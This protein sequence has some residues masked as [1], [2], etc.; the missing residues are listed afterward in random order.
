MLSGPSSLI[1]LCRF[2]HSIPLPHRMT[3]PCACLASFFFSKRYGSTLE[4]FLFGL[5]SVGSPRVHPRCSC[6]FGA[7]LLCI[8]ADL[9]FDRG[10]P[11]AA[12]GCGGDANWGLEEAML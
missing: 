8:D 1:M 9:A 6:R 12:L 3:S 2:V 7:A 11:S 10:V 5:A 4:H